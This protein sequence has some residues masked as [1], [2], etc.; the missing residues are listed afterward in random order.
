[1]HVI[2]LKDHCIGKIND[3]AT[4]RK[5][6]PPGLRIILTLKEDDDI[7]NIPFDYYLA[8]GELRWL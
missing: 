4:F 2:D 7:K 3:L 1:M 6:Q 5:L 8:I